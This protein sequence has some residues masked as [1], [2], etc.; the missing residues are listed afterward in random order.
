M[1]KRDRS[2]QRDGTGD[3]EDVFE[4]LAGMLAK[5]AENERHAGE[6]PASGEHSEIG[7][8][9]GNLSCGSDDEHACEPA[10]IGI[11]FGCD[12]DKHDGQGGKKGHGN[13]VEAIGVE[14]GQ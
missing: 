13:S 2:G 10:T 8:S 6:P 3:E 4:A 12:G 7:A 5:H 9:V 11:T 1:Q 14:P